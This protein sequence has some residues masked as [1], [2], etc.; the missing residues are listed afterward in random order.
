[1][2]AT[3]G[4]VRWIDY[5]LDR[6]SD[7]CRR[8]KI[9]PPDRVEVQRSIDAHCPSS[10]PAVVKFMITRGAGER[11]YRPALNTKPTQILSISDWPSYPPS[12]YTDGI[13]LRTCEMR[14]GE[15]PKLAGLK[16]LCRLEQVL[17]QMELADGEAD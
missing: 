14:L 3:A 10:G 15:N 12:H 5:H 11:G 17:A 13:T 1:M 9:P 16:H 8:L 6:L 7:G 4:K 2:A